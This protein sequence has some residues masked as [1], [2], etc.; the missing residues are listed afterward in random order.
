MGI[1][2]ANDHER[3]GNF[4]RS[5]NALIKN[6]PSKSDDFT[7]KAKKATFSFHTFE[8]GQIFRSCDYPSKFISQ[9]YSPKIPVS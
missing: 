5:L 4:S 6:K 9:L 8:H 1:L 7:C 2:D 3:A